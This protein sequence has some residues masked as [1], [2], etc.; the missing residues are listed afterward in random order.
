MGADGDDLAR[1]RALWSVVN[2]QFTDAAADASWRSDEVVWGLFRARDSEL[3]VVGDV[4]GLDVVDL[5]GGT[6]YVAAWLHRRGAR[7]V[8]LDLSG[9][10]LATARRCQQLYGPVFPLLQA[11]AQR[12][13]LRSASYD[14][15]LSEHGAAAWCD[16]ERWVAEAARVLRPG[17]RLV[18]LTNSLLSALCVPED[19]GAAHERLLRGQREVRTVTWPGGGVEHHPSHGDWIRVL[20]SH[21]FVVEALHELYAPDDARDHEYYDIATADWAA[22]WPAEELWSARLGGSGLTRP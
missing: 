19:E 11:D 6:A 5:A 22:R 1:N 9:A 2:E 10:Q 20:T 16:P 8:S 18:F 7:V 14:L 13:P 3:G 17:G 21:G 12:L 15:V 4:A